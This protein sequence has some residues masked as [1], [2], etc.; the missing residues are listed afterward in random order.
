MAN[1]GIANI[2]KTRMVVFLANAPHDVRIQK[3]TGDGWSYP[4]LSD[5]EAL[6]E[7][8]MRPIPPDPFASIRNPAAFVQAARDV[9][10]AYEAMAELAVIDEGTEHWFM[11]DSAWV[12]FVQS[13]T[14]LRAELGEGDG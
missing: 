2:L 14:R 6:V 8:A 12:E 10:S 11:P 3:W 1:L 9:R 13:M 4:T 5:C 7:N